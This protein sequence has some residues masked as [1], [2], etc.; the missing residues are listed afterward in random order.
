MKIEN[1]D[2]VVKMNYSLKSDDGTLLDTSEGRS[3]VDF[4]T[5]KQNIIPSLEQEF[6]GR[7]KGDKFSVTI[8]FE[9]GYGEHLEELVQEVPKS[10]FGSD[11]NNVK[12][13]DQFQVE[14]QSGQPLIVTAIKINDETIVLD[15]NH[16]L[17][18]QNLNFDLEVVDVR[19]ATAEEIKRGF[20]ETESACCNSNSNCCD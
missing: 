4:I 5:G 20:V 8:P 9:N 16:P 17:A 18:G 3:T 10:E 19:H 12:V 7:E 11:V 13:G 6:E 15:G 14:N 2:L 1:K